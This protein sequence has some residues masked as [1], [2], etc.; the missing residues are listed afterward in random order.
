MADSKKENAIDYRRWGPA[1][2]KA[3]LIL[4]HGLGAHTGRWEAMGEFFAQKN[5]TSYACELKKESRPHFSFS[6]ISNIRDI[7]EKENPGKKIFLVGESMGGLASFLIAANH[8]G[9]FD[10]LI[11]IS[12]AFEARYKLSI[13]EGLRMLA[14][15]LYDPQKQFTL[16]FDSSMCTR[17]PVYRKKLDEDPREYRSISSKLIFQILLAQARAVMVKKG[18]RMPALFLIAGDDKLVNPQAAKDI[19]NGLKGEDKTLVEF[20]GM[21]HS[22][23]IDLGREKVFQDMMGWIGKRI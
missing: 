18:M 9:L 1:E 7:A 19:F 21:Y 13:G 17:D 22:L 8:P 10:G 5:I 14:P 23:S 20:P 12:P 4:I 11:C 2:P 3:V 15:L 6:K 16:P